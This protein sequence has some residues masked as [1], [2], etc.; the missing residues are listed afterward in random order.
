MV[1]AIS[2]PESEDLFCPVITCDSCTERITADNKG[3]LLY[4]FRNDPTMMLFAH[5]GECDYRLQ[6][7]HGHSSWRDI[8]L[9]LNHL[10]HNYEVDLMSDSEVH[11]VEEMS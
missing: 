7:Q 1:V 9:F 4:R 8:D 10:Q 2:H 6:N 3:I 5:K 11:S